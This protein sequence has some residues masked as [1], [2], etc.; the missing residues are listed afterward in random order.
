MRTFFSFTRGRSRIGAQASDAAIGI[1]VRAGGLT[2][3]R[4][5]TE[6]PLNRVFEARP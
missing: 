3:F 4:R 5:A 1:A 6:T 2:R